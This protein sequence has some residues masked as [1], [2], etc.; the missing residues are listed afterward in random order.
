MKLKTDYP[1]KKIC[2]SKIYSCVK[3]VSEIKFLSNK[4]ILSHFKSNRDLSC[5][6]SD[7]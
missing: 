5:Q 2:E 3:F 6:K 1:K 4:K 7:Y